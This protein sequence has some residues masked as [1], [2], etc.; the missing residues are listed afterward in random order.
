MIDG[1]E[2]IIVI[3]CFYQKKWIEWKQRES[4]G[5]FVKQHDTEDIMQSTTPDAKNNSILPNGNVVVPT[6]N[7][8]VLVVKPNGATETAVLS[9]TKTQLTKSK[10]WNSIISNIKW[11]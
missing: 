5:G 3:P 2:G 1:E 4:G 10:K 8:F 6:A 11:I 7:Y 9:M